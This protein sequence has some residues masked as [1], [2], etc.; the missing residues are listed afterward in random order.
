MHMSVN[1]AS[2]SVHLMRLAE[3]LLESS[4]IECEVEEFR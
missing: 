3:P 1:L 4:V 2:N